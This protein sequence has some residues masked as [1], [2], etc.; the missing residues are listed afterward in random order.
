M[1]GMANFVNQQQQQAMMMQQLQQ[2]RPQLGFQVPNVGG[3]G[4]PPEQLQQ[5][6]SMMN[7]ELD[8]Q[9]T[10]KRHFFSRPLQPAEPAVAA[11]KVV[12]ERHF[13]TS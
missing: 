11:A 3:M 7:G 10:T 9:H 1:F 5:L 4:I 6:A 2:L 12:Q 13:D 8:T